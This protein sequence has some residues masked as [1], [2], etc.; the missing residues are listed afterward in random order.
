MSSTGGKID[1]RINRGGAPYCFK[2]KGVN[3]HS[4]RSFVPP[5]GAISKFCQLYIY[6]TEDEVNNRINTVKGGSDSVD[7]GIVQSLLEMLD[8]HN[9]LV[10]SFHMAHERIEHNAVDELRL[11]LIAS[12][13]ASGR[14]N[15]IGLSHE[16]AGL[17]VTDDYTKRCRDTIIHSRTNGLERIYAIYPRFMQLQYPLL[18]PHEDIGFYCQIPANRPY[19]KQPKHT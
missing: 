19:K 2:V 16:V 12:S 13:S 6:D 10:K 18:V 9:R 8:E 5:D 11:V 15:H 3:Y 1:H 17:I 14:P 7:E 4:I